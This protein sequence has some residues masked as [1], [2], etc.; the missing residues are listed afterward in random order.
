M[1]E[2]ELKKSSPSCLSELRL[3][4]SSAAIDFSDPCPC[5]GS[6]KRRC[7]QPLTGPRKK[8]LVFET[9]SRRQLSPPDATP[10]QPSTISPSPPGS[11]SPGS[12]VPIAPLSVPKL[13][14]NGEQRL[15]RSESSSAEQKT[16]SSLSEESKEEEQLCDE[17]WVSVRCH[18]GIAREIILRR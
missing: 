8:L 5:C 14:M 16:V 1:E 4:S 13:A 2:L 6:K 10:I 18:C 12:T 11:Q 3:E 9:P 17:I 7:R 15:E